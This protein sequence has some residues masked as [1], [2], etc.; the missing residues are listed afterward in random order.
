MGLYKYE[1]HA[2][3][4]E[5][6]LCGHVK[7]ADA[8]RM[9]REAGYQGIVFTDHFNEE[10][11]LHF[12]DGSWEAKVDRFL[13]G[14]KSARDVA[15]TFDM[16]V[17]FGMELRFTENDNDYLVY[18]MDEVSMKEQENLHDSTIQDFMR[19]LKGRED[20]LVYQAHP[21]RD[22]C[23]LVNPLT[24]HGLE[25]HNKN[26]RHD[27]RDHLAMDVADKNNLLILSGSDFHRPEDLAT[28]GVL[29][30]ERIGN[31]KDFV[32]KIKTIGTESLIEK[33]KV[34]R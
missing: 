22:G 2:H 18:G 28:G 19:S 24:V 5:A 1:V 34:C 3:T 30:D 4:M 25:V 9:Y 12:K 33:E 23:T 15:A 11:F 14:F 20:I 8:V 31:M 27:S 7:A 16:D 29:F 21:F 10:N 6:S 17:L 26:P 13:S 32:S